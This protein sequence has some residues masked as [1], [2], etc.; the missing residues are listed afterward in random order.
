MKIRLE[1]YYNTHTGEFRYGIPL[2]GVTKTNGWIRV[3]SED[4]TIH[5][6]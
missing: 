2:E 3:P 4:K 1:A 6:E 5:I